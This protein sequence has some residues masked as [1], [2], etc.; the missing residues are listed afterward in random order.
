VRFDVVLAPPGSSSY[1]D[2]NGDGVRDSGD[3]EFVEILNDEAFAVDVSGW[4]IQ[5][6]SAS[7]SKRFTFPDGS[8]LLPAQ[9]AV[10][11]GGGTAT[12]SFGGAAT[13]AA[14][15]GLSLTDSPSGT[16]QVTLDSLASGGARLDNF[17]Y[18]SATFGSSCTTQCASQTRDPSSGSFVGHTTLSGS[19]GILWS[20]GVSA[21][22][23][24]P[25]LAGTF[26]APAA[27]STTA[28][29]VGTLTVQF[30]MFMNA[31]D[32]DAAHV[33]LFASSCA[34]P[35]NPVTLASVVPGS[36]GSRAVITPS[37]NLQWAQPYCVVA[38][39]AARSANNTALGSD[40]S[41]SFTTVNPGPLFNIGGSLSGLSGTVVLTNQGGDDLPRSSPGP[42]TFVTPWPNG[43]DY[44]V[45]VKTQPAGQ[46]CTVD[47]TTPD[48][49]VGQVP[50]RD[51]HVNFI[52]KTVHNLG[53]TVTGLQVGSLVLLNKGGDAQTVNFGASQSFA[54]PPVAEA[55]SYDVTVGT[56]PTGQ[57][58]VVTGGS[59]VM[60]AGDVNL[61]VACNPLVVLLDEIHARPAT[62]VYG[63]TNGDGVRDSADDEFVEILNSEAFTVDI[64]NLVVRVGTAGTANR[65]TFPG[66]TQLLS[67]QRA[68]VFGGGA[69]T[70]SFGTALVFVANNLQLTDAPGSPLTVA[71][72]SKAVSGLQ[73]DSFTYDNT[74]FGN[75][76][77]TGCASRTRDPANKTPNTGVFVTHTAAAGAGGSGSAGVLWSPGTAAIGAIPKLSG[78][79]SSPARG[80]VN[81]SV[82]TTLISQFNMFM[83]ALDNTNVKLF[84]SGCAAST[85]EVPLAFTPGSDASFATLVPSPS[86]LAFATTYC[87]S[88]DAALQNAITVPLGAT[89]QL[90]F[91]TRA[92]QSAPS[93]TVVISEYGGTN[94]T[95][96]NEFVELYNPTPDLQDIS[97]WFIQ[98]RTPGGTASCWAVIPAATS[99]PSHSY[100]LVGG[101]A[102]A[103]VMPNFATTGLTFPSPS[104]SP[105]TVLAGNSESVVLKSAGIGVTC[106]N[107][108]GVV[109]TVSAGTGFT[110]TLAG[111]QLPAF[112]TAVGNGKSLERKA[113][114][115][116]TND[117]SSTG[118]LS[119]GGHALDGNSERIG[120]SNSDFILRTMP[121][122]QNASFTLEVRACL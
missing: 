67:G 98:R 3:D 91:T 86:P 122:P 42:F 59:G 54:F 110:D 23:A 17:S 71:L 73:L 107:A 37:G 13:F 90:E 7:L 118:M 114:Y 121:E 11:F 105:G 112:P 22:K 32:F 48:P 36:D 49:A 103:G 79:F 80:A 30:N 38:T 19:P 66:G 88:A 44:S 117:M 96:N 100:F 39:S 25:K 65:F 61:A 116:S 58:C 9:R 28:S 57:H 4:V 102:F 26:S 10:V 21:D 51:I 34:T 82:G 5:T 40:G 92:A 68:V 14:T 64:G 78:G 15:S 16:E 104:P 45:A 1:A 20:P 8:V 55:D 106:T 53:G 77:T 47:P 56:Q 93:G 60:G 24:I 94:F 31:A 72:L 46:A 74:V 81:V 29:I 18:T 120:A 108:A 75:S 95:T 70:G 2:S 50:G 109:D 69:P 76:C 89:G 52:C 99:M 113:C 101:Q 111:L 6:G 87:I 35:A 12:G 63:D 62:G 97:G 85:N 41:Y 115:D 83:S 43:A 27:G 84:A 119:G 33:Q